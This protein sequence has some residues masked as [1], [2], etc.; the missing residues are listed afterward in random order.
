M[1]PSEKSSLSI[2]SPIK[3]NIN[4]NIKI[5]ENQS[6]TLPSISNLK[7]KQHKIS[8]APML[9]ITDNY[10]RSFTRLLTLQA[11]LYTEMIHTD[12]IKNSL[13]GY[14]S[15]LFFEE[16]QNPIV[17]QLGGNDP[18]S[19][20]AAAQLC[21][22]M[23]YNE[24]NL[25]CGCP[26]SK[27]QESNFGAKLMEQPDLVAECVRSIRNNSNLETSV[28]CRLGLDK[29]EL[30]FLEDFVR[31]VSEKGFVRHFIV[32]SRIAVMGLDTIKNRKVP[33]L[34]YEQVFGLKK[35]FK[36]INFS[37]NGGIQTLDEAKD[38]LSNKDYF[39]FDYDNAFAFAKE[40]SE[41]VRSLNINNKNFNFG[42]CDFEKSLID[43]LDFDNAPKINNDNENVYVYE[44]V[45]NEFS[46]NINHDLELAG[47]MIG[48]AAYENP[49]IL[50][51][52]DKK[53]YKKKN[54][55][56]SKKEVVLKYADFIDKKA[57]QL[58][59]KTEELQFH[60]MRMVKPLFNL[61][62]GEKGS[63]QFKRNLVAFKRNDP[64]FSIYEHVLET[65]DCLE[66]RN[67][68]AV[69]VYPID[70]DDI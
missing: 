22:E 33:P 4:N 30:G 44:N 9:N 29:F 53:F 3:N 67:R 17:I 23:G 69:E 21:K 47:C 13:R 45:N 14:K 34:R 1:E 39:R 54:P 56:Y 18:S 25:N 55:G 58:N 12:T 62:P 48:R 32:H 31:I 37:L 61:F 24:I 26:S 43:D 8:I 35:R 63:N 49:W 28:K 52:V 7:T 64:N 27:V 15:E 5:T 42:V 40:G 16:N 10:F 20:G 57:Q 59:N 6:Q 41:S 19:L 46:I 36:D 60:Y 68:A 65:F 11:V 66:K 50:S 51:N 70:E 2:N 38:I